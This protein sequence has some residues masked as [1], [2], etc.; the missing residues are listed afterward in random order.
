MNFRSNL[1]QTSLLKITA[2]LFK[3]ILT[4][5]NSFEM[6]IYVHSSFDINKYCNKL[7]LL[8]YFYVHLA[9]W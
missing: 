7:I 8:T 2:E 6:N 9:T 4:H 1:F 3:I 5:N